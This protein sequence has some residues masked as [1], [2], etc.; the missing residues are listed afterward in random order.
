MAADRRPIHKKSLNIPSLPAFFSCPQPLLKGAHLKTRNI[1]L[2]LAT[3]IALAG[4]YRAPAADA[5][6]P[7]HS[8]SFD[9][10]DFGAV[11][12]GKALDTDAINKAIDAANAAGGGT[13]YFRAGTYAAFS[14]HLK[15]N[16]TLYLDQGAILLAAGPAAGG[17]R[18]GA[19]GPAT[20]TAPGTAT[21]PA[22]PILVGGSDP[23]GAKAPPAGSPAAGPAA[24]DAAEP[25]PAGGN[26]QDFGH[27]H[28]HNSFLWGENIHDIS[29]LGP[30]MIDGN[31]LPTNSGP[32]NQGVGNKA[33]SL[34]QC[35]NVTLRDFSFYRG[36]WF[37]I[38]ATGVDNFTLDNV[39]FDTNRDGM[40]IDSCKNVRISNCYVNSPADDGICLKSDYALGAPRACENITITNCQVSA[41]RMGT[42]LDGTYDRSRAG[43]GRIKF[44]TESNGGFKNITISNC[45]FDHC[46]G[47]ALEA[48]D[49]A[50]I[51]DVTV[52]NIAMREIDNCPIFIRLGDRRRG[53]AETTPIAQIRRVNISNIFAS[54]SGGPCQIS[55]IPG[56]SIEDLMISNVR[57][58]LRGGGTAA[59]AGI[60]P[61]ENEKTYPEPGMF[62]QL[63]CS[64]F[65]FR[66]VKNLEMH[67]VDVTYDRPDARPAIA[68]FDVAGA[69]F[70]HLKLQRFEN[71]P[72]FALNGVTDF[73]TQFVTSIAD[74]KLDKVEKQVI[75]K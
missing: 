47:L 38:L 56:H 30:G 26:Y 14:I 55:G 61:P 8:G 69:D 15:S 13:V 53:P 12:D 57:F 58:A 50:I 41:F 7:A 72:C 48:V 52:S 33:L 18:G 22:G 4:V 37:C 1:A 17:G 60:V 20:A 16:V 10:H 6:N 31:G 63:P 42:L 67:H 75:S 9:P 28:F 19:R 36:G 24:Y 66:H 44:G 45:V 39:K 68:L 46:H 71:V 43:T 34:R 64:G 27:T 29:I 23:I 21:A 74:V 32:G 62:G 51:E 59:Q 35:R 70:Q 5:P 25:N 49:G 11:G 2:V 73:S 54:S 3:A 65:F 40:D